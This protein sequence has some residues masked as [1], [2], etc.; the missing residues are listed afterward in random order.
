MKYTLLTVLVLL[1][2]TGVV[3]SQTKSAPAPSLSESDCVKCHAPQPAEVAADGGAHK[4]L[5]CM[6][7]H[8]GHRPSSKNN[9]P[10]CSQCHSGKPHFDLKDCL[11][12]HKNPHTP[13]KVTFGGT[14]TDPC[15]T[16]HSP[17]IKQLKENKS[18]HTML[19]CS[20]CHSVHREKPECTKCHKPHSSDMAA[21]D[22]N[23]C[24]KAHMPTAVA[25]GADVPSKSCGS[26]H[27][28]ALDLLAASTAK[29]NKFACAFCHPDKHKY[30]P[31]CEDCH[32]S[33]HP[34]GIHSKFPKCGDCHGIAHNVNSWAAGAPAPA[35]SETPAPAPAAPAAPMAPKKKKM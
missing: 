1:G 33:P 23:K 32:G 17:Q 21:A 10:V 27:K 3:F 34:A 6:G 7:C 29:H 31:K 2:L 24:H 19:Y 16:C 11:G 20:T 13:K 28:K 35:K 8:S 14:V 25:Y 5:G 26:C 9:I 12:C 15:L 30:V 4:G 22:C 18:K